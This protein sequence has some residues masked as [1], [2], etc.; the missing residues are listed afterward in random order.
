MLALAPFGALS[1]PLSQASGADDGSGWRWGELELDVFVESDLKSAHLVGSG[2]LVLQAETSSGPRLEINGKLLEFELVE[3]AG[4]KVELG[5]REERGRAIATAHLSFAEPRARGAEVRV[6][7]ECQSVGTEDQFAV[8]D[9]AAV[10]S[11]VECWYPL[12][13]G[14]APLTKLLASS[15]VTRFHLPTGW[16]SVSN[17]E[18][19]D[20]AEPDVET[21][22]VSSPVAR[23]F[24]C[25]PYTVIEQDVGGR[26]VAIHRLKNAGD[27]ADV[28]LAAVARILGELETRFGPYPYPSY[29]VAELPLGVGDFLGSSEQ[30]FIMVRPVA[31]DA[32]DGNLA[33][34]GH[35]LAHGWWGNL[36]DSTGPGSMLLSEGLAQFSAVVAIGAIEGEAAAADFLRFSRPGYVTEQCARGYFQMWRGGHDLPLALIE[37]GGDA[38]FLADSKGHWMFQ[39]LRAEVGDERFFAVLRGVVKDFAEVPLTLPELRARFEAAAPEANLARFFGQWLDRTGA[40]ILEA[41]W[42][43]DGARARVAIR[44]VQ[45]GEPYHLP[46]EVAIDSAAGRRIHRVELAGREGAFE[47]ESDGPPTGIQLDPRH[48]LLIWTEEYGPRPTD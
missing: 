24:A 42:S 9:R 28:E 17:G 45:T 25:A 5:T 21:W 8:T 29:R 32:P 2:R 15:G 12:P 36:I 38:H 22:L 1:P 7:F 43:A 41:D 3:S 47:L 27:G 6:D 33:L 46:L 39:M 40:P 20:G 4:A 16:G 26:K 37:D 19:V 14:D 23:S 35:E 11:W 30:G 10:A 34:F 44:Q 31:F 18:R 13:A 48:R